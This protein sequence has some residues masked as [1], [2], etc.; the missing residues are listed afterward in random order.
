M[1]VDAS[2]LGPLAC[3]IGNVVAHTL[4]GGVSSTS[5]PTT[6]TTSTTEGG[7][8]GATATP[9]YLD[10]NVWAVKENVQY[11]IF[12]PD[13]AQLPSPSPKVITWTPGEGAQVNKVYLRN[14]TGDDIGSGEPSTPSSP[15]SSDAGSGEGGH[16]KR[17]VT[18]GKSGNSPVT[19]KGR[20]ISTLCTSFFV[21]KCS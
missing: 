13:A 16:S 12:Y 5:M 18:D 14:E 9:V 19:L 10:S 21:R 3:L 20:Y 2:V 15:T 8:S 1:R 7:T 17:D 4:G 6:T 11:P